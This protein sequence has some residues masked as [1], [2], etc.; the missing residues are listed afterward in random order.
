MS[1]LLAR[2]SAA[3]PTIFSRALPGRPIPAPSSCANPVRRVARTFS[4]YA[5]DAHTHRFCRPVIAAPPV[6]I[7]PGIGDDPHPDA[8]PSSFVD[9]GPVAYPVPVA[10]RGL[11]AR[12][13]AGP[14]RIWAS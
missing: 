11:A 4:A 5:I 14:H 2:G 8:G 10:L 13:T 6:A 1:R 7:A 9:P 3:L 12:R